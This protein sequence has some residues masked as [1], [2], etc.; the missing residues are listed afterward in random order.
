M[1]FIGDVKGGSR[2]C[3]DIPVDVRWTLAISY[4]A[5]LFTTQ[6][7]PPMAIYMQQHMHPTATRSNLCVSSSPGYAHAEL[8]NR[9][10]IRAASTSLSDS[11]GE[12]PV[13]VEA[14][15]PALHL[16]FLHNIDIDSVDG[17]EWHQY[18][19]TRLC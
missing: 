10:L 6:P 17:D 7:V 1:T 19:G 13:A 8:L 9:C 3:L 4:S 5:T 12:S 18:D 14:E 2:R 16:S 15:V 11:A